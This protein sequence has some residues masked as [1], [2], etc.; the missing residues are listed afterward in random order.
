MKLSTRIRYGVR[1]LMDIAEHSAAGPV[2]LKDVARRQEISEQYLEQLIL[3]L[4]AAGFVRSFRGAHGGFVL[5]KDASE[6]RVSEL[7]EILGGTIALMDCLYDREACS[8]V[9]C[10][11][12]RDVWQ[13][14]NEA[15]RNVLASVTLVDLLKRQQGKLKHAQ[16]KEGGVDGGDQKRA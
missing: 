12:V 2:S 1:A 6:I 4:K 14:A 10:C 16:E 13:E 9:D 5:S 3:P 8:R 11:A 7:V 15:L